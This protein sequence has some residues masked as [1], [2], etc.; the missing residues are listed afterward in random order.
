[1]ARV[2]LLDDELINKIAAGEVVE[3]PASVVKEVVEN[4]IDAGAQ[5]IRVSLKD[6]GRQLIE[7]SDDG[8][9]MSPEDAVMALKRHTTSKLR[10]ADDLFEVSTMGFRGEALASISSVSRFTLQTMS[11][12]CKEGVRVQHEDGQTQH[13]PWQGSFGTSVTIKDLFFNVPARKAFMKTA[14]AEFAV[15]HEYLQALA[16]ALPELGFR[17]LHNDKEIFS[18][19]PLPV[20]DGWA[21]GEQALRLR[22]AAILGD[23]LAEKL[24]YIQQQDRHLRLEALISPPGLDKSTAKHI[25]SFVNNRWV[26]DKL[27]RYGILRGYHS[28]ILRGKFPVVLLHVDMDAAL[29]DVNVHPAK[30]ELRFQYGS[31]VQSSIAMAIRDGLRQGAWAS[32]KPNPSTSVSASY[33]PASLTPSPSPFQ[34]VERDLPA[35]FDLLLPKEKSEEIADFAATALREARTPVPELEL[36]SMR[37]PGSIPNSGIKRT[38]MSFDTPAQMKESQNA[39]EKKSAPVY[40]HYPKADPTAIKKSEPKFDFAPS[41][42]A[43]KD[44]P[45]HASSLTSGSRSSYEPS[46]ALHP[47]SPARPSISIPVTVPPMPYL[48]MFA[49]E[50]LAKGSLESDIPWDELRFVGAF[51]RCF[52]FFEHK[53]QLL[54]VDQHAFHERILYERL[55]QNPALLKRT[56]PLLMP[57]V[58][59]FRPAECVEFEEK[60]ADLKAL[61]FDFE[62]VSGSEVEV[63][64]VPALL[65]NKDIQGVFASFL[66]GPKNHQDILHDVLASVACHAAVRAGEELPEPELK[67]LLAEAKTVDFFLNCPHGRRVLRWWKASQVA[68]WFDRLG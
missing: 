40:P 6:G 11:R 10:N 68:A 9:G 53:E 44:V 55:L 43:K 51:Q 27:L 48:G 30:T 1:M 12:D 8:L 7:I 32:S 39:T 56:Q 47:V 18:V 14:A 65:V 4:A 37:N 61:G 59:E 62:V 41:G 17:L 45:T 28:H 2:H 20:P 35:D 33:S 19:S 46:K 60:K 66:K 31:E 36:N 58:L 52:L 63:R 15:C 57:E 16:L 3:R 67:Q 49:D 21:R 64:A 42:P 5:Q 25:F 38:T 54:V 24:I 50:G 13:F 34:K 23:E 29:V 26:K 22:T